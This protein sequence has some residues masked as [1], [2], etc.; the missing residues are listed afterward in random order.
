MH[1]PAVVIVNVAV[2]VIV[3]SIS[4]Y[5]LEVYPLVVDEV[6]VVEVA[7]FDDTYHDFIA[8]SGGTAGGDVPS[9]IG[10]DVGV[11][12]VDVVPLVAEVRVVRNGAVFN[13]VV[14]LRGDDCGVVFNRAFEVECVYGVGIEGDV[15]HGHPCAEVLNH[16]NAR[17]NAAYIAKIEQKVIDAAVVAELDKQFAFNKWGFSVG[18]L[19]LGCQRKHPSEKKEVK[20]FH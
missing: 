15:P 9:Q 17:L 20:T 11:V 6:R 1:V 12:G 5:F 19:C 13:V 2:A 10:V 4:G 16:L 14:E 7:T 8:E 3:D 18:E